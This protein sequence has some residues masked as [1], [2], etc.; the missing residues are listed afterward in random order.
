MEANAIKV[1]EVVGP[2]FL[3]LGLS[4]LLYMKTWQKIMSSWLKNHYDLIPLFVVQLVAGI[5]I[6]RMYSSWEWNIW[7]LV[8][9]SGWIMIVKSVTYFLIPGAVI[10][11]ALSLK[12]ITP[13]LALGSLVLILWG[14]ILSYYAYLP[15]Q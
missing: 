2:V 12:K 5:M 1:A 4:F 11:W 7:L 10:K 9:L 15:L 14:G 13:L 6:V 8:T 3:T